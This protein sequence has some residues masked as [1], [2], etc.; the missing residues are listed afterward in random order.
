MKTIIKFQLDDNEE[1]EF[2][3]LTRD[4]KMF[5]SCFME[6]DAYFNDEKGSGVWVSKSRVKSFKCWK[7]GND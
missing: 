4:I 5:I 1:L 7:V 2:E 3:V 6:G